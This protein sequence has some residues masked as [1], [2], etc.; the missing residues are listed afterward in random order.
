VQLKTGKNP[1][2]NTQHY[3]Q[4]LKTEEQAKD[5]QRHFP[6]AGYTKMTSTGDST[7]PCNGMPW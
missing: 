2:F 7:A 5:L 1:E 6:K 3:K 4:F